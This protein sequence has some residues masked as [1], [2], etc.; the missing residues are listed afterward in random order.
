MPITDSRRRS[1]AIML[2]SVAVPAVLAQAPSAPTS[3]RMVDLAGSW[4][5]SNDE[6][7]LTRIDPGPELENYT[8][9]PLNAAGR[10]ALG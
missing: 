5:M 2:V 7:L 8:G 1:F 10:E 6:E 3:P 9:F 4:A